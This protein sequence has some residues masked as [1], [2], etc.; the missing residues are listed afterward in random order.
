MNK[1]EFRFFQG[2][3][4]D[5]KNSTGICGNDLLSELWITMMPDLKK[6]AFNQG[7]KALL[8]TEVKMMT[9]IKLLVVSV[10]QAAIHIFRLQKAK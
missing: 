1:H 7:S 8:D 9:R 5:Y 10:V 4:E 2:E 3:W 6:L